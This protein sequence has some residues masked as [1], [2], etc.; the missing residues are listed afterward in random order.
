VA[1]SLAAPKIGIFSRQFSFQFMRELPNVQ[2]V[3]DASGLGK[4]ICWEAERHFGGR[5]APVNFSGKKHDM[6][7]ALMNQLSVAQKRFPKIRTRHR[8]RLFRSAEKLSGHSL[9]L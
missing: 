5:F 9:D 4:Q 7:F 2:A 6:G 8:R 3:G 1:C